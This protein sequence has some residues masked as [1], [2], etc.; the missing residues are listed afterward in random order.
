MKKTILI[1]FIL[2]LFAC[3]GN[4][5]NDNNDNNI[6]VLITG[7]IYNKSASL[8][9]T[10]QSLN[11]VFDGT[12]ERLADVL[13]GDMITISTRLENTGSINL[14]DLIYSIELEDAIFLTPEKWTCKQCFPYG[15]G[16]EVCNYVIEMIGGDINNAQPTPDMSSCEGTSS[17]SGYCVDIF[18]NEMD[19]DSP[20]WNVEYQIPGD[21]LWKA[22]GNIGSLDVGEVFQ[23]TVGFSN[24]AI[25]VRPDHYIGW[26][27]RDREGIMLTSKAYIFNVISS[28]PY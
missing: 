12:E 27:V 26:S 19:C 7:N 21:G 9:T 8:K 16:G 10:E 25:D 4:N 5:G 17:F 14:S 18:S 15:L 3:G 11:K 20:T 24:T 28:I 2:L 1:P 6:G 23:N 22:S 13:Q